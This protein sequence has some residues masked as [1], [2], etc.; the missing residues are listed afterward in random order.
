MAVDT[1]KRNKRQYEW[2]KENAD[3]L[4]FIMP[5]G[6]KEKIKEAAKL[7]GVSASAWVLD[8]IETKLLREE[9]E[10]LDNER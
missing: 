2:I 5:K 3:R 6:T 7:A 4:S 8:A 1:V 9:I 10:I